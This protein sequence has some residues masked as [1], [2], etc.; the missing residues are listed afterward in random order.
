MKKLAIISGLLFFIVYLCVNTLVTEES[1]L[2][3]IYPSGS[4]RSLSEMDNAVIPVTENTD[5]TTSSIIPVKYS[6]LI[7]ASFSDLEQ[8]NRVA[9]E[10]AG[11]FNVEIH[12]LPPAANG[13]YRIS[14]G[15]YSTTGEA[16]AALETLKQEHFP[17]AWLL[18]SK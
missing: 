18:T 17:D 9:E 6:Y 1:A 7:V 14:Y 16:I 2:D 15:S 8:A 3:V 4:V 5:P 12:V 13:Y 10:Y 11:K